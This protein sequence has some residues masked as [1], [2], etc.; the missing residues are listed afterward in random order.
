MKNIHGNNYIQHFFQFEN[1]NPN[2][3]LFLKSNSN[4]AFKISNEL[5]A[6]I[7]VCGKKKYS[8]IEQIQIQIT[9]KIDDMKYVLC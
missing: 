6:V 7:I 8:S 2:E 1:D 9:L 5:I 4:Y 3:N